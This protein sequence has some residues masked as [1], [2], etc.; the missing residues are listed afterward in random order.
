MNKTSLFTACRYF[1]HLQ[2]VYTL[3]THLRTLGE[4]APQQSLPAVWRSQ[5]RTPRFCLRAR[6]SW[7][8]A[9]LSI[10]TA[11]IETLRFRSTL[12]TWAPHW[13]GFPGG[14]D[15]KGPTCGAEGKTLPPARGRVA[16]EIPGQRQSQGSADARLPPCQDITHAGH[17]SCHLLA[18]QVPFS[19][20]Q[21]SLHPRQEPGTWAVRR[22]FLRWLP[23]PGAP[24]L[25]HNQDSETRRGTAGSGGEARRPCAR[26]LTAQGP[27]PPPA[28][29]SHR[30]QGGLN[31]LLEI[32]CLSEL[33]R[34]PPYYR[35][36]TNEKKQTLLVKWGTLSRHSLSN[37]QNSQGVQ[38]ITDL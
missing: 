14:S 2:R 8:E 5:H 12:W 36:A 6:C 4:W 24:P 37:H 35:T 33:V 10:R 7:P 27:C 22:L 34:I 3:H 31:Y 18:A 20:L 23:V 38:D 21:P 11:E 30:T 9:P 26:F 15:S 17:P 28:H 32:H 16:L 19:S 29:T 1:F 25:G 13:E